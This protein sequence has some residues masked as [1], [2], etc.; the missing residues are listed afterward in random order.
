M[1]CH[2]MRYTRGKYPDGNDTDQ[3]TS[4]EN[5]TQYNRNANKNLVDKS[6]TNY[7]LYH[8]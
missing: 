2:A 8:Q 1:V 7:F 3:F 4:H 6:S 5:F